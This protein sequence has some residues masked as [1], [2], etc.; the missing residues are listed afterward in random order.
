MTTEKPKLLVATHNKGKFAEFKRMLAAIPYQIISLDDL[1]IA[2]DVEETGTTYEENAALKAET[3]AKLSGM[4][5]LAD[6][7]GL[8]IDALGGEPGVYSSRYAG[9]GK[10]DEQKVQFVLDKLK[11]VPEGK[12]QARFVVVL[13]LATPD[14]QTSF[15]EGVIDGVISLKPLGKPI[16]QLP[17]RQI[18]VLDGYGKTLDELDEEGVSFI[19]HRHKA[20]EKLKQKLLG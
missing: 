15:F 11:D 20:L 5:T 8:E 6:D 2:L 10:T 16:A 9:P 17:Y 18:F 4:L 13:A 7:G 19:T 14:G 3:Y 1:D 12:R